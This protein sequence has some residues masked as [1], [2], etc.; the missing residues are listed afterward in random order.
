MAAAQE[1]DGS[2]ELGA[3][4]GVVAREARFEVRFCV[5]IQVFWTT[6]FGNFDVMSR[7]DS[8]ILTAQ[9]RAMRR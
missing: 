1:R 4:V 9:R 8:A 6:M 2:P 7:C 5:G 3:R